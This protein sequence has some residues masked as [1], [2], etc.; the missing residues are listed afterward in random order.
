[1]AA[2][3]PIP[4]NVVD[5]YWYLDECPD[6]A[7][8]FKGFLRFLNGN[9]LTPESDRLTGVSDMS[10]FRLFIFHSYDHSNLFG[11]PHSHVLLA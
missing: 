1:M 6:S 11:Q 4:N 8:L 10:K 5:P 9:V 2:G 7:A 3:K